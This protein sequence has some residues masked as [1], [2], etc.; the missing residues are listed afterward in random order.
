MTTLWKKLPHTGTW[1]YIAQFNTS[2]DPAY[3]RA[4]QDL[5]SQ[6]WEWQARNGSGFPFAGS[7]AN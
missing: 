3:H 4:I 5:E 1:K 2:F 6:G 7:K